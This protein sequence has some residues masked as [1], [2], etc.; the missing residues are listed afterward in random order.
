MNKSIN[1]E[2]LQE[3]IDSE[4]IK[5]LTPQEEVRKFQSLKLSILEQAEEQLTRAFK[6]NDSAMVA[7]IAEVLKTI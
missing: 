5:E 4:A 3:F 2:K 1:T 6:N 7:A